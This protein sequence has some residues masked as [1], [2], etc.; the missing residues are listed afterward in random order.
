MSEISSAKDC[1]IDLR[2]TQEQK[3]LLELAAS[4]KGISLS[5]YTLFHVLSVAKQDIDANERLVLS[6]R[7]RDLFMSV[8]ENP[9]EL[10]GKLKSAIHKY[11]QKYDK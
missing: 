6:N 10:K 5:A 9:P 2:V 1:R 3:E 7:D 8:M 4:L 11:R